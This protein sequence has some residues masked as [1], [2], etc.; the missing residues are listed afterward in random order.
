M[1]AKKNFYDYWLEPENKKNL[2]QVVEDTKRGIRKKSIFF[3]IQILIE[4]SI[5]QIFNKDMNIPLVIGGIIDLMALL[6][7]ILIIAN[8][9]SVIDDIL[10]LRGWKK[11]NHKK[12]FPLSSSEVNYFFLFHQLNFSFI[13]LKA[14]SQS[15][16]SKTRFSSA[17]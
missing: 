3:I 17:S 7:M 1:K 13:L 10:F 2:L 12:V 14:F 16:S 4:L 15:F 11:N 5:Y 8:F 6:I 9:I